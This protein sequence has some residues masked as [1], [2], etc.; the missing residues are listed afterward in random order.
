MNKPDKKTGIQLIE[1]ERKRQILEE[2]HTFESDDL[3]PRDMLSHSAVAYIFENSK[4]WQFRPY[5][6][7]L[8]PVNTEGRVRDLSKAG[9]MIAAEIDKLLRKEGYDTSYEPS[10]KDAE[11]QKWFEKIVNSLDKAMAKHPK[12]P[13][14]PNEAT[15]VILEELGELVKEILQY[16]HEPEKGSSLESIEKEALQLSAMTLRFLIS[17]NRYEYDFGPQHRQFLSE[18]S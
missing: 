9:A 6:F 10:G 18:I 16:T 12:W 14:N 7:K 5:S 4:F 3:C 15:A 1:Q 17:L 8:S 13:N 11:I 2:Q